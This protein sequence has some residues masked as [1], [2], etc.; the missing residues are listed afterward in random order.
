MRDLDAL[1]IAL[2]ECDAAMAADALTREKQQLK[3]RKVKV[4]GSRMKKSPKYESSDSDSYDDH[5][6]PKRKRKAAKREISL[7]LPP[8]V[9]G[10]YSSRST[11]SIN[12]DGKKVS[13]A[14]ANA[15]ASGKVVD[16]ANEFN[17]GV[18]VENVA[19]VSCASPPQQKHKG[20]AVNTDNTGSGV[21][22][23]DREVG[24]SRNISGAA[25][26]FSNKLEKEDE[27]M[28]S[29]EENK[30]DSDKA[31]DD[32]ESN[33][34]DHDSGSNN[35][36]LSPATRRSAQTTVRSLTRGRRS[37]EATSGPARVTSSS[38]DGLS[39]IKKSS[40][41]PPYLSNGDDTSEE[42]SPQPKVLVRG[43]RS[44][45][46]SR[47]RGGAG[48]QQKTTY[49]TPT[50][51]QEAGKVHSRAIDSPGNFGGSNDSNAEEDSLTATS[52]PT[53]TR[54]TMFMSHSHTSRHSL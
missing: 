11:E 54:Q 27:M 48:R 45:Q 30:W 34:E 32:E 7:P 44:L 4:G 38:T 16:L 26:P 19:H 51:K 29:S 41:K 18:K 53:H 5:I 20:A 24:L 39:S 14:F 52:T 6:K 47:T 49:N 1:E 36:Y 46:L 12:I 40:F 9:P 31:D 22:M 35:A 37:T 3:A 23:R 8:P 33:D 25:H 15:E 13:T 10:I 43:N 21:T 42:E 17:E 2:D 50:R 28:S